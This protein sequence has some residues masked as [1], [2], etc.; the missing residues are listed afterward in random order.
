MRR[1]MRELVELKKSPPEGVRVVTSEDNMLD[2]TG[3]I[4]GPGTYTISRLFMSGG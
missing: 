2:V 1:L 4:E 3:I